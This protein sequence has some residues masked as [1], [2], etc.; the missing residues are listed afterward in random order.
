MPNRQKAAAEPAQKQI[1]V[2]L[3]DGMGAQPAAR[4]VPRAD[5][6]QRAEEIV[7][8]DVRR[9]IGPEDPCLLTFFDE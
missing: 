4:V 6:M 8:G 5:L 7:D 1:H 9:N 3:A 2:V